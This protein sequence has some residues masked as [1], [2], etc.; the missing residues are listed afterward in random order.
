MGKSDGGAVERVGTRGKETKMSE[1]RR[2]NE[3]ARRERAQAHAGEVVSGSGKRGK[4]RRMAQMVSVRLDGEL[5]GTLRAIAE[6]RGVTVSDLLREG[7]E[8]VVQK[9][10]AASRPRIRYTITGAQQ[11]IPTETDHEAYT[12]N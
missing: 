6:E 2:N 10:Y 3:I 9:T 1:E 7:A 4:P 12:A 8:Q 5:V 11:A